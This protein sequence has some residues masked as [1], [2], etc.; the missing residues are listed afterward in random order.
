MNHLKQIRACLESAPFDRSAAF[1][2]LHLAE[3]SLDKDAVCGLMGKPWGEFEGAKRE[4]GF[5]YVERVVTDKWKV[6]YDT[7][8]DRLMVWCS[9]ETTGDSYG[10]EGKWNDPVHHPYVPPVIRAEA[11]KLWLKV[12]GSRIEAIAL[13]IGD[14][15]QVFGVEGAFG[16]CNELHVRHAG[17]K[18]TVSWGGDDAPSDE[19][20]F[21]LLDPHLQRKVAAE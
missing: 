10:F 16:S 2:E 15:Y 13:A 8:C 12:H 20:V 4:P 19:Q 14:R 9:N 11:E 18:R 17:G 3:E 7:I 6:H 21:A 5:I 1:Q